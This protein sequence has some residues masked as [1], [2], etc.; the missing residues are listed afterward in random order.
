MRDLVIV[1]NRLPFH[2]C[3]DGAQPELVMSSG[4]LVTALRRIIERSR[5]VWIGWAGG[6]DAAADHFSMR[7]VR[8]S[9]FRFEP[10]SLSDLE[11]ERFYLGFSNEIVWP[12]FHDLQS[13]CNFDPVYWDAYR[14][15][16]LKFAQSVAEQ[17]EPESVVWVHDYHLFE[18][19]QQVRALRTDVRLGYFH[20][21]PFPEWGIFQK[22]PWR[23]EVMRSLMEYDV[24]GFQTA[25]DRRNF[26]KCLKAVTLQ[27]KVTQVGEYFHVRWQE[28]DVV[29]GAFPISIDLG[30]F[31]DEAM[32]DERVRDA[33][34]IRSKFGNCQIVL[35]VDRLDYTKGIPERLRSFRTLLLQRPEFAGKVCLVQVTVPSREDIPKYKQL[36]SEIEQLVSSINGQFTKPG[37]VPIHYIHR[38]LTRAELVAFYV[39]ADV[40]LVTPLKDG[41]NLVA[42]EYCAAKVKDE[43]VLILSEFAG[44]AAELQ[45][46][47]LLVNPYDFRGTARMIETACRMSSEERSE[48]MRRMRR[49][50]RRNDV[51]R[52]AT[53]FLNLLTEEARG[54][55]INIS[56]GGFRERAAAGSS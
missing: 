6:T 44:S 22:L 47:A 20:H 35:G 4:G 18:V 15:V 12:L 33:E 36:K 54:R 5:G 41:M 52:W 51:F 16:N 43:G 46:G 53:R 29:V 34:E 2:V 40:A 24:I 45:C 13:R 32:S 31:A 55:T 30:E 23:V 27:A 48:R 21:I 7:A 17:A 3:R 19:G 42:K 49:V 56:V 37:W 50:L 14:S 39:A 1:S 28:R 38:N 9:R 10:V 8:H 26:I 11:R 25:S